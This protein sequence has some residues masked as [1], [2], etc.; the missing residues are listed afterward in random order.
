[1]RRIFLTL[2]TLFA[3]GAG[4]RAEDAHPAFWTIHGSRGTVYIV[5]SLHLLPVGTHWHRPELEH[6]MQSADSFVFEVPT[7]ASEHA[8][9]TDFILRNGVLPAGETLSAKL[10]D[11][12]RR[13]FRRALEMAGMEQ[14]N[15]DQKQPW[16]AEIV[17]SVQA[18]YRNNY[19]ARH[20]PEGEAGEFAATYGKE[21]RYL[22]TTHDQLEFLKGVDPTGGF[23]QFRTVLADF[24]NQAVRERRFVD[25]WAAGDVNLAAALVTEGLKDLPDELD[26]LYARN[27]DWTRQIEHMLGE[28]RNFYVAVGIAH[29]VGPRGVP[30]LLRAD[31]YTVEGP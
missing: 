4:A 30:A 5:S 20:T 25:A 11:E 22:D 2:V 28:G 19:S 13:D 23:T 26:R 18:M 8:E 14:D 29:L 24:P 12:G 21:I 31:G 7:G 15:L 3:L 10:D 27:R 16:L 1:M 6:A 17:L 9:A